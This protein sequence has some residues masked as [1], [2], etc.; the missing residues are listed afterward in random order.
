MAQLGYP[1]K[2]FSIGFAGWSRSEERHA[3]IVAEKFNTDHKDLVLQ[4]DW[5]E[6]YDLLAYHYDEPL[7]GSS[8]MPTFALSNFASNR[9]KV[10]LGGDGGDELFGG[11]RWYYQILEEQNSLKNYLKSKIY[12]DH[13][14]TRYHQLMNWSDFS[15]KEANSLLNQKEYDV[16]DL[17]VYRDSIDPQWDAIK[18]MQKLDMDTFLPE[19]ICA[20]VDRASMAHSLEVR[21]PFLNHHLFESVFSM[22]TKLYYQNGIN[23][24]LLQQIISKY[25]PKEIINKAK[26]G[27]GSPIRNFDLSLLKNGYL[28][29][30]GIVNQN[31]VGSY[32][33][34][35]QEKRLWALFILENW[36]T[37]WI[38]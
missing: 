35:N 19:V 14:I 18:Q 29:S 4:Q 25:L 37:H 5:Q 27:F 33:E 3:R 15:F 8:F 28:V 9:V 22:P 11:Y 38:K 36:F 32:I 6:S 24:K 31:M 17:W 13:L 30:Q 23:K 26:Q 21:V 2:S 12:S 16:D 10:V 7:G 34:S 20:K 1:T